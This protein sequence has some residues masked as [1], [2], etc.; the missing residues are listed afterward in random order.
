MNYEFQVKEC[1][2]QVGARNG[3]KGLTLAH[4]GAAGLRLQN[5]SEVYLRFV[6]GSNRLF[7]Y[8]IVA[9]LRVH[10]TGLL[11]DVLAWNCLEAEGGVMSI[12][13]PLNA[14]VFHVALPVE[15]LTAECLEKDI[16]TFEERTRQLAQRLQSY[17]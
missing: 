8:A 12:S 16:A 4:D 15:T 14:F 6:S 7:L 13:E 11:L 2:E 1:I 10:R 3:I 5:D 9:P 17:L